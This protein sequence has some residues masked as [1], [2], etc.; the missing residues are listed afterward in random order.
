MKNN[1]IDGS[2]FYLKKAANLGNEEAV[3]F[4][5]Q[6]ERS[7]MEPL[8]GQD[9]L[10]KIKQLGNMAKTEIVRECGYVFINEGGTESPDLG[11]F[12]EALLEAKGIKLSTSTTDSGTNSQTAEESSI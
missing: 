4:L 12:Y 11:T 1:K 7:A 8:K 2:E 3:K 6:N 9:L 10:D 5:E